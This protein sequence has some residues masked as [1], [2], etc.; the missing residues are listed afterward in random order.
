MKN[1]NEVCATML[2]G[3][4]DALRGGNSNV[5]QEGLEMI[6]DAIQNATNQKRLLSTAEAIKFLRCSRVAFY[7][8]KRLG[9]IRGTKGRYQKTM[10]YTMAE[11]TSAVEKLKSD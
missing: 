1:L 7:N 8:L 2:E 4:V 6:T 3:L 5:T 9:I 11:L 10:Y